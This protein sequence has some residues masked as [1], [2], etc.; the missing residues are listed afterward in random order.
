MN[1][2]QSMNIAQTERLLLRTWHESA[3]RAA[4]L[5]LWRN[6]Q[7]A[8]YIDDGKVPTA[9][10]I[11]AS[12]AH[13][14]QHQTK[15]GCQLWAVERQREVIGCCGFSHFE[16]PNTFEMVFHFLPSHWSKGYATEAGQAALAY[17]YTQN[18][19]AKVV[20]GAHPDNRASWRVLDKLGFVYQGLKWF[21]DTQQEEPFF[22]HKQKSNL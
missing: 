5:T 2:A 17:F 8:R 12:L 14:V 18:P 10:E 22:I 9:E 15:Y 1:N 3:D 13:G 7:V 21:N 16:A 6:P 11:L 19:A 4:A 20:A